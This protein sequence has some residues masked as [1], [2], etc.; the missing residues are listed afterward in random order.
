MLPLI[1]ILTVIAA[2]LGG[3]RIEQGDLGVLVQP[4]EFV[5]IWGAALGALAISTPSGV[6]LRIFHDLRGIF[7]RRRH[8][9]KLY[10]ETLQLFY[11]LFQKS[12]ANGIVGIE[13]DVEDPASS[14]I[15][16]KY[17]RFN[18]DP[19][20]VDF[21]CD[22]LRMA[23][24][25]GVNAF[26][27]DQLTENDI[28]VR[29]EYNRQPVTSLNNIA[30]ALPGLGIVAAVLGIVITMGSLSGPQSE[31]GHKVAAALV[32]T[33]LGVL[34]CYGFVGPASHAIAAQHEAELAYYRVLKTG[35]VAF[36]KG[37][38]PIMALEFARRAIPQ[39]DRPS[40]VEMEAECRIRS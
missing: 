19:R 32:G 18:D 40:F 34:T 11:E 15:F 22:T 20:A 29:Q 3:Y 27:V 25:G 5:I 24:S 9:K 39:G 2:V 28:D 26:D 36:V 33:F 1:G 8:K 38:P 10:L 16:S 17:A 23:I 7:S 12:R 6:I 37:H 21:V 4:A 30:D 14:K 35:L 13:H 31:I